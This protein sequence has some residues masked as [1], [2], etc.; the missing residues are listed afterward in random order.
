MAD[1]GYTEFVYEEGLQEGVFPQAEPQPIQKNGSVNKFVSIVGAVASLALIT[2]VGVWSYKLMVRDVS[3][4]PV[5]RAAEG[6]MRVQPES[7]GGSQADHQG[8]AVN[9]IAADG[10]A[11][12]TADRLVLAPRWVEL[13]DSDGPV[14][15]PA[16]NEQTALAAPAHTP[17]ATGTPQAT[18]NNVPAP[19]GSASALEAFQNGSITALVDQLTQGVTPLSQPVEPSYSVDNGQPESLIDEPQAAIEPPTPVYVGPGLAQSLRPVARPSNLAKLSSTSTAMSEALSTARDASASLDVDPGSLPVGT[20]LAQLG[21]YDSSDVAKSE[22]DRIYARFEDY[23]QD[24]KRV[25]EKA[26][27]G[28]RTFYR[29]RAMGFKDLSDARRFCSALVAESADCIPVTTR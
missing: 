1:I 19:A 28:G 3:G 6:P 24:K 26:S 12:P 13:A 2:G 18:V 25:I 14:E 22:W 4:V 21:A 23:M 29:L 15:E 8:L 20:R 5:V 27:S 10:V 9:A 16:Q 7:P 11:A 17:P